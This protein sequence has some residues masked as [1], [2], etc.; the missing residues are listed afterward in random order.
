MLVGV[1]LDVVLGLGIRQ[2]LHHLADLLACLIRVRLYVVLRLSLLA[3]PCLVS[4]IDALDSFLVVHPNLVLG[5]GLL[6]AKLLVDSL[7]L[8][9][10]LLGLPNVH[11]VI[12]VGRLTVQPRDLVD[13]VVQLALI[14][15]LELSNGIHHP[16]GLQIA[17]LLFEVGQLVITVHVHSHRGGGFQAA[18]VRNRLLGAINCSHRLRHVHRQLGI[19]GLLG[20]LTQILKGGHGLRHVPINLDCTARLNVRLDLLKR[21]LGLCEVCLD[22]D[23]A[24]LVG[25]EV[26][27][28]LDLGLGVLVVDLDVQFRLG[29]GRLLNLLDF[30][31]KLC[32]LSFR[33]VD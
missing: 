13:V 3:L 31:I 26:V 33:V 10:A 29:L 16:H 21:L 28:F 17:K 12:G 18:Q 24:L 19:V 27:Q 14:F 8:L 1:G 30:P 7:N 5:Y 22:G 9:G 25:N 2:L 15:G 23:Q 20:V 4:I 6:G 11:C 32:D